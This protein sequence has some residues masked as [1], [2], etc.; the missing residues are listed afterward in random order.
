V[1]LRS[2]T[3]RD[4]EDVLLDTRPSWTSLVRPILLG[5]VVLAACI[6]GFVSWGAAPIWFAWVLL[7]AVLGA[8]GHVGVAAMRWRTTSIAVTTTRV[9][10]RTGV[11]RR[12]GREV[13]IESV[14]DV[15]YRQGLFERL[16]HA[17]SV[18][19]ESAGERGALP[20]IDV[21]H[22]ERFQ[23][24][25]NGAVASARSERSGRAVRGAGAERPLP[26]IPEQ[27]AQLAELH[28][29][30]VLTDYEFTSKKAELLER[31]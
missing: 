29:R 18:T 1:P 24:A 12:Y 22:P 9:V 23:A 27:I 20:F 11:L 10:Y 17:G 4:D 28:E 2:R 13:P 7:A 6:A 8:A 31:M 25:V 15:S 5:L 3:I 26:S 21:P 30:G 16:A 14:Q 19:V